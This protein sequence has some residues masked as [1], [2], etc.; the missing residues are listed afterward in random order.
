MVMLMM[1][2]SQVQT[3]RRDVSLTVVQVLYSADGV[4]L[5]QLGVFSFTDAAGVVSCSSIHVR[6]GQEADAHLLFAH[7]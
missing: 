3:L 1:F 5:K 2:F 7:Q 4:S 6:R